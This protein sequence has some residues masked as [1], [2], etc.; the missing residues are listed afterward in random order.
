MRKTRKSIIEHPPGRVF[1]LHANYNDVQASGQTWQ[2][3][4]ALKV[5][6]RRFV[7]ILIT[8][9]IKSFVCRGTIYFPPVIRQIQILPDLRF[10][11]IN[12]I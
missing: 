9:T 1:R 11:V 10:K 4:S 3:S 5:Y 8:H 7:S 2:G 6:A 12:M